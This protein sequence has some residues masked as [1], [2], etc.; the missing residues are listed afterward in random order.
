MSD[1]SKMIQEAIGEALD[2]IHREMAAEQSLA[3][4]VKVVN[5]TDFDSKHWWRG[6][7]WYQSNMSMAQH[8]QPLIDKLSPTFSTDDME[9]AF[10]IADSLSNRIVV[11]YPRATWIVP[12]CGNLAGELQ[13]MLYKALTKADLVENCKAYYIE[14]ALKMFTR[15]PMS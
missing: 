12:G 10:A 1:L 4:T 15:M 14:G 5:V 11:K 8:E 7:K 3:N 13:R 6:D 2:E 9:R